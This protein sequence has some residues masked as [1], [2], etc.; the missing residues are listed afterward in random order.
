MPAVYC[1]TGG[2]G[3]I[4]SAVVNRLCAGGHHVVVVDKHSYCSRPANWVHPALVTHHQVDINNSLAMLRILRT[5]RVTHLLHFAAQ[6]HVGSSFA[7]VAD[8]MADN[9]MGTFHLLEAAREYAALT[10]FL[11]VSTDEV[12]G[13]SSASAREDE[14]FTEESRCRATNPYAST[15]VA[16]EA[17]AWSYFR[18]Y[19]LPVV[20][21]RGNNVYGP[22]QY[23]EKLIPRF[24]L[25]SLL[26]L[27]HTVQGDGSALR[28]FVFVED[29]AEA[30]LL[31]AERAVAGQIYNIGSRD[32]YSVLQI[33]SLIAEMTDAPCARTPMPDRNFNDCRYLI[34]SAK[35]E[36][37][38][39]APRTD[40][41]SGL[42]A[43]V[44]WYRARVAEYAPLFA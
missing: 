22:G 11:H 10:L 26:G 32:E 39:W 36:A 9:V 7:N 38:G 44:A 25:Q 40:F 5:H 15:K 14:E 23:P 2:A 4:G 16:A 12:Y 41:I 8:F 27:P 30:F 43:T 1:I 24:C 18:S 6:T 42:A 31:L 28:S 35:L 37:L 29:A 13:E 3:F 33:S 21:T 17:L 19:G 34:S 20:V